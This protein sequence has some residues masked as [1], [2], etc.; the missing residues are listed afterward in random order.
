VV[1]A[2][3]EF[4]NRD[5]VRCLRESQRLQYDISNVPQPIGTLWHENWVEPSISLDLM[6]LDDA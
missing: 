1:G 5:C 3:L 6:L 4:R 2:A